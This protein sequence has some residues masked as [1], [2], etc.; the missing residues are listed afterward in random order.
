M[1]I[2]LYALESESPD[3]IREYVGHSSQVEFLRW[4]GDG[5]FFVSGTSDD[6]TLHIWRA[7]QKAPSGKKNKKRNPESILPMD[8]PP[9]SISVAPTNHPDSK[10]SIL[11]VSESSSAFVWTFCLAVKKSKKNR[12][13]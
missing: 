9:L 2:K 10:W 1:S 6:P 11:G 5:T 4:S 13:V 12:A 8:A 7:T 3:P